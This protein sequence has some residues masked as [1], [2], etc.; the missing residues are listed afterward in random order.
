MTGYEYDGYFDDEDTEEFPTKI[1]KPELT[2]EYKKGNWFKSQED[3]VRYE[4]MLLGVRR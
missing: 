1:R 2:V 4:L 3:K